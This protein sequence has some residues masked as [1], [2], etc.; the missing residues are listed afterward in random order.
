MARNKNHLPMGGDA[1]LDLTEYELRTI[2]EIVVD[3]IMIIEEVEG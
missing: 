2:E 3:I 1:M